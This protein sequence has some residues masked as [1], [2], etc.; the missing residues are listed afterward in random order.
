[1]QVRINGKPQDGLTPRVARRL[2][3]RRG[4]PAVEGVVMDGDAVMAATRRGSLVLLGVIGAL[5]AAINIA[6]LVGVATHEPRTLTFVAPVVVA[7]LV[8]LAVLLPIAFRR[9]LARM[10]Q[11]LA[12]LLPQIPPAGATVLASDQGLSVNGRL[13]AWDQLTVDAVDIVR[14]SSGEGD[15]SWYIDTLWLAEAGAPARSRGIVLDAAAIAGGRKLVDYV[16]RRLAPA[17]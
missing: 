7:V 10:E 4:P 11:R 3:P 8:G 17:A 16:W 12:T 14:V 9:R 5:A 2:I 6:V 13:T 1:M 15:T